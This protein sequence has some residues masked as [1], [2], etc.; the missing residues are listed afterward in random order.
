M[1]DLIIWRIIQSVCVNDDTIIIWIFNSNYGYNLRV[2]SLRIVEEVRL[3]MN[4]AQFDD[5]KK[6]L[7]RDLKTIW[8][9][10]PELRK[11]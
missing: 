7:Q 2:E 4:T 8:K 11:Q 9:K 10:T 6:R 1:L 5:V 3:G